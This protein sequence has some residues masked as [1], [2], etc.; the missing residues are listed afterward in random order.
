VFTAS[1][2]IGTRKGKGG[3]APR[4]QDG[5]VVLAVRGELLDGCCPEVRADPGMADV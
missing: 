3:M 1:D 2:R 5:T 4:D